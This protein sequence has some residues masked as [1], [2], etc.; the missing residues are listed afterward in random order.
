MAKK[1]VRFLLSVVSVLPFSDLGLSWFSP[2]PS[3]PMV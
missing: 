1:E 2:C 3:V